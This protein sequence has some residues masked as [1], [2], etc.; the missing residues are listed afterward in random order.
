MGENARWG[1]GKLLL[2]EG[3]EVATESLGDWMRP[4]APGR[5]NP[6]GDFSPVGD[7]SVGDLRMGDLA[8][9]LSSCDV[10]GDLMDAGDF[11]SVFT[12]WAAT[13]T[14]SWSKRLSAVSRLPSVLL[15]ARFAELLSNPVM[16]LIEAML[17]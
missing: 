8:G 9:T 1:D 11:I 15:A 4:D 12:E 7:L 14:V 17:A 10:W 2:G 3:F 6:M 5:D 13:S 16:P